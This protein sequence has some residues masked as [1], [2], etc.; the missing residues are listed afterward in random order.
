MVQ[1]RQSNILN[2]IPGRILPGIIGDKLGRFNTIIVISGISG[3]VTLALWIPGSSNTAAIIVYGA[4]FG[5]TSGGYISMAPAVIAQISDIREI[6]T[7][8]GVMF[9]FNAVTALAGSPIG[10]AI[11]SRTRENGG[12]SNIYIGLQLF[13]GAVMLVGTVFFFFARYLQAGFKLVRI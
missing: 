6:G 2:S 13:C 1:E 11:V 8:I 4:I 12:V 9:V 7:R 5:F 10:G 3:A